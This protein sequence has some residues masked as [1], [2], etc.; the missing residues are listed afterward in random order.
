[1]RKKGVGACVQRTRSCLM[2][3]QK[4]AK[5]GGQRRGWGGRAMEM[6]MNLLGQ[7]SGTDFVVD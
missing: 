7:F 6:V 4:A 2:M 1:M 3:Q 5:R